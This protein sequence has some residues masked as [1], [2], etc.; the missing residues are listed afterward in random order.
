[1]VILTVT[2]LNDSYLNVHLNFI[3][4]INYFIKEI[5]LNE[6]CIEMYLHM[7]LF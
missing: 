4:L 3:E 1:M 7:K 2:L 6:M 5:K